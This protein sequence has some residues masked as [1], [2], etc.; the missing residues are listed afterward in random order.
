M[1]STFI[2]AYLRSPFLDGR[3]RAH[4]GLK[5]EAADWRTIRQKAGNS[6]ILDH[7]QDRKIVGLPFRHYSSDIILDIDNHGA[8]N[9][10]AI[11]RFLDEFTE[12]Y[13]PGVCF[14]SS[15]N[16]GVHLYRPLDGSHPAGE[17]L[18]FGD[19]IKRLADRH[20]VKLDVFPNGNILR[21]PLGRGGA[22]L[23]EDFNAVEDKEQGFESAV[24]H[25][26][27]IFTEADLLKI[28][29]AMSDA[30]QEAFDARAME[31][32]DAVFSDTRTP[33]RRAPNIG[34][35]SSKRGRSERTNFF[36]KNG[37][38]PRGDKGKTNEAVN[39]I[40]A[41]FVFYGPG[42]LTKG[43]AIEAVER[44]F[45]DHHNGNSREYNRNRAHL[46]RMIEDT[47]SY[48]W[49]HRKHA[50]K[51]VFFED[52]VTRQDV[53]FIERL[54]EG[55]PNVIKTRVFLTNLI[56]FVRYKLDAG[57]VEMELDGK[58]IIR[59]SLS[60]IGNKWDGF[61]NR[62]TALEYLRL[63]ERLKIIQRVRGQEHGQRFKVDWDFSRGDVIARSSYGESL[64]A[65]HDAEQSH[66]RE[67][68][69]KLIAEY[70][71]DRVLTL[72]DIGHRTLKS[73]RL[74]TRAIPKSA[75]AK[76]ERFRGFSSYP[77][78]A[79]HNFDTE[80][81]NN[82]AEGGRDASVTHSLSKT[83]NG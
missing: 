52:R 40:S 17:I 15:E 9:S 68:I 63:A 43:Q 70:G 53:D 6:L 35:G 36:L 29:S 80:H 77:Q 41:H 44:W 33:G 50:E 5:D 59:L 48:F 27:M 82:T 73:Y 32:L 71:T 54:T 18:A 28:E 31:V 8:D 42:I 55:L 60:Y 51:K 72:L 19:Q 65:V 24:N 38:P 47:V 11:F 39:L 20:G 4:F 21:L 1:D 78:F 75:L 22:Y 10:R 67:I 57:A 62:N 13:G 14:R 25:A 66:G 83:Y 7:L 74:G 23:D 12:Q 45:H 26:L 61:K 81:I 76:L 3:S 56:D 64:T 79:G 16:G 2:D 69:R 30:E 58:P 37:I 49:T 46:W 34:A